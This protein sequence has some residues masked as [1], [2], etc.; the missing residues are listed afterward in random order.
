ML[1]RMLGANGDGHHD[2]L[3]GYTR[4]VSG[5]HFFAPSQR[6]LRSLVR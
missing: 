5:A 6:T 1:R 3:M 4:A 2:H